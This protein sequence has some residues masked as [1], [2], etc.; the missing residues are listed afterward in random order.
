MRKEARDLADVSRGLISEFSSI[1]GYVWALGVAQLNRLHQGEF[2]SAP[3]YVRFGLGISWCLGL[4]GQH[5]YKMAGG[6]M[7]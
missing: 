6:S 4:E 1:M 3:T 5:S 7:G 2:P